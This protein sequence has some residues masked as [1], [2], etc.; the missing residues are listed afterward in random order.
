MSIVAR[1]LA[2]GR[3]R[4]RNRP[5]V[6]GAVTV[7]SSGAVVRRSASVQRPFRWPTDDLVSSLLRFVRGSSD[8]VA[9]QM[10]PMTELRDE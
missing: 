10:D 2:P 9:S 5:A 3:H 7:A 8:V 6:R 4:A 1:P